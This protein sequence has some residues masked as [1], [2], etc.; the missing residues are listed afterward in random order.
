MIG[1]QDK[2][3]KST[4]MIMNMLSDGRNIRGNSISR[5]DTPGVNKNVWG[6]IDTISNVLTDADHVK[7]FD[8]HVQ[9]STT[10][11]RNI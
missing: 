3:M 11:E 6:V 8:T 2:S 4:N 10:Q 7:K 5:F 9:S 1:S